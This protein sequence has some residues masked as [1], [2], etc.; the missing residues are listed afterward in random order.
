MGHCVHIQTCWTPIISIHSLIEEEIRSQIEDEKK[1]H[2]NKLAN[3]IICENTMHELFF[4]FILFMYKR[5]ND[6]SYKLRENQSLSIHFPIVTH[7]VSRL[8]CVWLTMDNSKK[9]KMCSVWII[10]ESIVIIA[11][12]FFRWVTNRQSYLRIRSGFQI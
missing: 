3:A 6:Y 12:M 11:F 2:Q 5:L 10:V 4:S 9:K 7:T 8:S 1:K